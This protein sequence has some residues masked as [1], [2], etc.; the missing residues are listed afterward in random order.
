MSALHPSIVQLLADQHIADKIDDASGRRLA[1]TQRPG[2]R[3]A[4][5]RAAAAAV[6]AAV[7]AVVAADASH[8][9]ALKAFL[10]HLSPQTSYRRFVTAAQPADVVD[11]DVMLAHD[12][13]HRSFVAVVDD[14]IVAHAHAVA[15]PDAD[16]VELG[17]VVADEWQGRGIGPRLVR[18]LLEAEPAASAAELE[19]LV[20]AANLPARRLIRQ[21]WPEATGTPEGE[22]VHIRVATGREAA[23]TV[24]VVRLGCH[25]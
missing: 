12:P 11:L 14:R 13:C 3:R 16:R 7:P 6:P 21:M 15:A 25:A 23:L 24:P 8:R 1:R 2:S 5:R 10:R 19:F 9:D 20:L 4:A 22:L 17:V 18:A